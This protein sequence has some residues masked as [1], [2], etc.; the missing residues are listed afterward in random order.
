[1][2]VL[3]LHHP[4]QEFII[5]HF[6]NWFWPVVIALLTW[7]AVVIALDPGGDHPGMFAGPGLTV[8][9]P[10]NVGQGVALIDRLFAGDLA[11]FREVDARLPDHPPLGRLWIGLCHEVAWLVF[12]P[13][14]SDAPYSVAC[15]RTAPATAFAA[16]V[17]LVGVVAGRWYGRWAGAAAA[18]SLVLM[19][20]LFGHAHLAAL[21]TLVNVTCTAAVMYL[22]DQWG[23][24]SVVSA[25]SGAPRANSGIWNHPLVT[26]AIGGALFGLA[27]LTKVQAILLP[28]PVAVWTLFQLRRRAVPMLALWG[29]TGLVIFFAFW[30]HLWSA[31]LDHF[32]EYLGRT[33]NRAAIQVWYFGQALPDRDIPWHYPWVMFLA[34]VP[35]GLHLLGAYG[36]FGPE[37]RAWQ[38][39]RELLLLGCGVFPLVVFSIPGVAVY[40]GERLFST[41]FT[42]WA[43][44]IGRGAESARLWLSSRGSPRAVALAG[45]LFFAAQGYGLVAL[46]PCWLSYYN[47]AVGGLPGAAKLGLEVSYWGDGVTRTLLEQTADRLPE[48]ESLAVLPTLYPGQWNE[49][50][51]QSPVLRKQK[52]RLVPFDEESAPGH[53]Y[54]LMFMRPEYL[55]GQFRK[56]FDERRILAAVRRQG[57]LLAVLLDRQ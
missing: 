41:G 7:S 21:E 36:L 24:I 26:A 11:G 34:T 40:D 6:R 43:G 57:V 54:L 55:P 35:V 50:R 4:Y 5:R 29:L 2:V 44:F 1:M 47:L 14:D 10:F 19:P 33:T 23:A 20:R 28:L 9:E 16:L 31:P 42:L 46:A 48:G 3:W 17:I 18:L 32:R 52:L 45:A 49:V 39:P 51:L 56:P 37:R 12:P 25:A 13:I 38:S 30:P 8:D 53:R 27:L 22:A 15:A